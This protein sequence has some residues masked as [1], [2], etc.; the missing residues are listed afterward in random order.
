MA[1]NGLDGLEKIRSSELVVIAFMDPEGFEA[2]VIAVLEP[3]GDL[4]D[5]GLFQIIRERGLAGAGGDAGEDV[6]TGVGHAGLL[7]VES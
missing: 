2:E 3:V 7:K 1:E 5:G 4:F 6:A